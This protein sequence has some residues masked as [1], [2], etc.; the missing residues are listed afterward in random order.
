[1]KQSEILQFLKRNK[2]KYYTVKQLA[3]DMKTTN[4]NLS[5]KLCK[6]KSWGFIRRVTLETQRTYA[7]Y[8]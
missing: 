1:M 4:K 3:N 6:L 5:N 8:Y 2:G 7:Y